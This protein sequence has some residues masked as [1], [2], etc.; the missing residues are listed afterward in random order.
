MRE[1]AISIRQVGHF[2][3]VTEPSCGVCGPECVI[4]SPSVGCAIRTSARTERIAG[5]DDPGAGN[6]HPVAATGSRE[7]AMAAAGVLAEKF[8]IGKVGA[9]RGGGTET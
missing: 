2:G 4:K 7:F 1:I 3:N 6:M 5:L 8:P 9:S